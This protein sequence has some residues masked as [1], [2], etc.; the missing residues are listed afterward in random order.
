MSAPGGATFVPHVM[1]EYKTQIPAARRIF[2]NAFLAGP[3]MESYVCC[4]R[5]RTKVALYLAVTSLTLLLL[6]HTLYHRTTL[7]SPIA[8]APLFLVD[9]DPPHLFNEANL[10][11]FLQKLQSGHVKEIYAS[12]LGQWAVRRGLNNIA[13]LSS[14]D[15]VLMKER[16]ERYRFQGEMFSYY[17]NCY[18]DI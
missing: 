11:S 10:T 18:L 17:L 5:M 8:S 3:V 4:L 7:G 2:G 1:S 6:L 12:N 16:S 9:A 15:T 13:T 14:G